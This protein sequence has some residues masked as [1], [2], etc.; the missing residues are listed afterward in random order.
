MYL[1]LT[2]NFEFNNY[3]KFYILRKPLKYSIPIIM[4]MVFIPFSKLIHLL[5]PAGIEIGEIQ[6][7]GTG[8]VMMKS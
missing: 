4:R 3:K 1:H 7:A 2:T 8:Y 6:N 5:I